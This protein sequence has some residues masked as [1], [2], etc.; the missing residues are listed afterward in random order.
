M[1]EENLQR[2][3]I[4]FTAPSDVE[5]SGMNF[6]GNPVTFPFAA[7]LSQ[8]QD[9]IEITLTEQLDVTI[10]RRYVFIVEVKAYFCNP[11]ALRKTK[12]EYTSDLS[13]CNRVN[14]QLKH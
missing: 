9:Y 3:Y 11:L 4:Y 13:E 2:V 8:N 14:I 6:E 12:I 10:V 1:I 7:F 5:G